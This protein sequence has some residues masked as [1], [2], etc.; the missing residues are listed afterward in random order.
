MSPMPAP[1]LRLEQMAQESLPSNTAYLMRRPH[2]SRGGP[3]TPRGPDRRCIG[4]PVACRAGLAG[5]GDT[6][7]VSVCLRSSSIADG[8][9][10]PVAGLPSVAS[11]DVETP[12]GSELEH[13]RH[14]DGTSPGYFCRA[15]AVE[16]HLVA[17]PL[18]SAKARVLVFAPVPGAGVP[19]EH[20]CG[21]E[22]C[23][24]GRTFHG[25]QVSVGASTAAATASWLDLL[26]RRAA[27]LTSRLAG[28]MS[29]QPRSP[30]RARRTRDV[31]GP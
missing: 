15:H 21:S 25:A 23:R 3:G 22:P 20:S 10:A 6:I 7:R 16:S 28:M 18:G 11:A 30:R 31:A 29:E 13:S 4:G 17:W 27:E 8:S 9:R 5:R 24:H 26:V 19:G 1:A 2:H 14:L 12:G